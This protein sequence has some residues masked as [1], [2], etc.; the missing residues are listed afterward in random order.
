MV[1]LIQSNNSSTTRKVHTIVVRYESEEAETQPIIQKTLYLSSQI[2][3]TV[4]A[5]N[6]AEII[7]YRF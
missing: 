3:L 1:L 2:G 5:A 4:E 7:N 6:T